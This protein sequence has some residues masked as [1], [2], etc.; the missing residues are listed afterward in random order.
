M[1]IAPRILRVVGGLGAALVLFVWGFSDQ[2]E[3]WGLDRRGLDMTIVAIGSCMVIASAA[4]AC[5]KSPRFVLPL[6]ILG[7]RSYEV[8]LTHMF[9]VFALFDFYQSA[10]LA[11]GAVPAL[12]VCVIL[13]SALL[14]E[15]VARFY[16]EPMNRLIRR[17]FGDGPESLGSVI[18]SDAAG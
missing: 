4:Q 5:W 9:V 18:R 16:T 10:D 15:V 17:R 13:I 2:V 1:T 12:F 6:V 8:Y 7:R 3:A 11:L 14:G